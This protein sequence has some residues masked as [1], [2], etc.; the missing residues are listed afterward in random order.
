[1]HIRT[2]T[3]KLKVE[4]YIETDPYF[5]Q[6]LR[7][8]YRQARTENKLNPHTARRVVLGTALAMRANVG[9]HW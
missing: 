4:E 9:R 7:E 3:A 5:D 2:Y 1:M 6:Y 8:V